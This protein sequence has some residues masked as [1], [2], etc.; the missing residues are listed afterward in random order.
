MGNWRGW[1]GD[2]QAVAVDDMSSRKRGDMDA[3]SGAAGPATGSTGRTGQCHRLAQL[4]AEEIQRMNERGA[5]MARCRARVTY[6]QRSGN[7]HS[8]LARPVI[9][10]LGD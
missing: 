3:D 6:G 1:R 9:C 7:P 8:V 10:L 5:V 2:G 4:A